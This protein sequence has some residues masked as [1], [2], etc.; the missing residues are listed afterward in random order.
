MY[1]GVG[2]NGWAKMQQRIKLIISDFDGTILDSSNVW[3]EVYCKFCKVENLPYSEKVL[4]FNNYNDW[5]DEIIYTYKLT[6]KANFQKTFNKIAVEVYCQ[7]SPRN[8]FIEF[9]SNLYDLNIPFFIVSRENTSLLKL[10]L[11]NFK[12]TKITDV[13]NVDSAKR[14]NSHYYKY[15]AEKYNLKTEEM[16]VIDDSLKHC[17]AAKNAGTFVVGFNDNHS[18]KRQTEMKNITDLYIN[19][20]IPLI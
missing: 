10:W 11:Q 7:I 4:S 20:F 1:L 9:I 17:I 5:I 19:N 8:G 16:V 3:Q 12:I 6:S 14:S 18:V 2:C 15:I 13:F